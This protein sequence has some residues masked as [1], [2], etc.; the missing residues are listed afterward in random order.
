LAAVRRVLAGADEILLG[1]AF[2]QQ[3]GI[4][5][6]ERQLQSVGAGR[7]VTT[8][9]FGSTTSQGLDAARTRGLGVRIL[10]PAGGTFHPKLYLARHGDR[11]AAAIG[12]ANL[13]SGLVATVEVTVVLHGNHTAPQ[14][15]TLW[16]V[17]ESWWEHH[18]ATDWSP[19]GCLPRRRSLIPSPPPNPRPDPARLRNHDAQ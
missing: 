19:I 11:M 8:T 17:A 9:V 10:N 3:R 13:A 2:V 1:V 16:T 12:S 14:L 7:L 6:L 5:L 18:D 4:N 15:N